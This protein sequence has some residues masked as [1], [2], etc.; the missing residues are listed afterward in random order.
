[1]QD[2]TTAN[3]KYYPKDATVFYDLQA[4]QRKGEISELKK[5][6]AIPLKVN[7][8]LVGY[9]YASFTYKERGRLVVVHARARNNAY[10]IERELMKAIYDIT[11]V[12]A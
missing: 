4:R 10:K 9:Y 3:K 8:H 2:L 5:Q 7:N 12:E 11:I 6:V 1:M